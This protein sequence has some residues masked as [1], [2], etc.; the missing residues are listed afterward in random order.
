ILS[1]GFFI[2]GLDD[3]H[4]V[5]RKKSNARS[6]VDQ[7]CIISTSIFVT[8]FSDTTTSKDLWEVCKGY[9]NV[10]DVYI[11]N[12]KSKAGKRFAFVRFIKVDNV[13]R[14]V[15]NLCT[16]WIGRMHLHANVV[17]FNR[18]SNNSPRPIHSA[19]SMDPGV[20]SFASVL[21]GT[22]NYG[23]NISSGPTMVLD[24]ECVVARDL[25]NFVMGE[26]K[27]FSSISNLLVLLSNEG[28]H[29]VKLAYLGG[30]WVMIQLPSTKVKANYMKHV[31]VASWSRWGE[32][33]E[34]EENKD[35]CFARKRICIKTKQED[36]ILEKF[37]I[38]VRGKV[39]VLRAKELFV[40]SPLF[41]EA[42]DDEFCFDDDSVKGDA[43]NNDDASKKDQGEVNSLPDS[44]IPYPIGFKPKNVQNLNDPHEEDDAEGNL[45]Q[46]HS[47]GLSS[48]VVEVMQPC[49]DNIQPLHSGSG[50]K[51]N[52]GGSILELLDGMVKVG[53]SMGL[54][55]DGC[56]KD[57]ERIIGL[58][59]DAFG[60]K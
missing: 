6:Y 57:M 14:L 2:I 5:S 13:D 52:N 17:R 12:R 15:G 53:H 30:L 8:N 43:I 36:N 23:N 38:I 9:G 42:T 26:V 29:H 18:P 45:S 60:L 41:K 16:L 31:G 33:L 46:N 20:S 32:V 47:K 55:M 7:T 21:K 34:L 10:V 59:R 3:W 11:P 54:S 49:N 51:N 39:F 22:P 44:S 1:A 28:F 35:D 4:E 50:H 27:D 24:D 56:V 19:R 40:W 58:Q 25:D 37:K 48:R